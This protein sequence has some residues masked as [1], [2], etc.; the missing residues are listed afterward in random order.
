LQGNTSPRPAND[1]DDCLL[2][3]SSLCGEDGT[4]VALRERTES[5]DMNGD[6]VAHGDDGVDST[7]DAE[8]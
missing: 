4:G 2:A 7:T 3:C 5:G 1:R 6:D 8:S